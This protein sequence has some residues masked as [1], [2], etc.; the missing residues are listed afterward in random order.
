MYPLELSCDWAT[1]ELDLPNLEDVPNRPKHSA[2]RKRIAE[3][4]CTEQELQ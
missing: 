2:A 1:V 3:I 4:A